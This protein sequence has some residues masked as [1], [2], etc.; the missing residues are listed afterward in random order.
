[1]NTKISICAQRHRGKRPQKSQL[2]MMLKNNSEK[3]AHLKFWLT[4][5]EML[6]LHVGCSQFREVKNCNSSIDQISQ[7][8]ANSDRATPIL[9]VKSAIITQQWFY[10]HNI[11]T[12]LFC[13]VLLECG[14]F[15][16]S[17]TW[18]ERYKLSITF[19]DSKRRNTLFS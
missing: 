14:R 5:N 12:N 15:V 6:M 13:V 4:I 8:A 17:L 16:T 9:K 11:N 10:D 7:T 1:M 3:T 19:N 18:L 2:I